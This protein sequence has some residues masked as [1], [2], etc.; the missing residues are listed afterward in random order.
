MKWPAAVAV[1]IALLAL[2]TAPWFVSSAPKTAAQGAAS[3][4]AAGPKLLVP[5]PNDSA[6]VD[7]YRN[8]AEG[9]QMAVHM[10]PA[11][12]ADTTV[13]WEKFAEARTAVVA[14]AQVRYDCHQRTRRSDKIALYREGHFAGYSY[15]RQDA[16][17]VPVAEETV[18]GDAFELACFGKLPEAVDEAP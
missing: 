12:S 14:L 11:H 3:V 13:V 4:M 16:G 2:G 17:P 5:A 1:G 18:E 8:R 6:W 7:Y 15:L 9:V 10:P